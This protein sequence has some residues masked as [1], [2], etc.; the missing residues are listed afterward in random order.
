MLP[1]IVVLWRVDGFL[2]AL[3]VHSQ[4]IALFRETVKNALCILARLN[5]RGF[6]V[7]AQPN[8]TV[9]TGNGEDR[10]RGV[11]R[12]GV[13]REEVRGERCNLAGLMLAGA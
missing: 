9:T 4:S 11:K 7:S 12:E 8:G 3:P 10:G 2:T 5:R 13:K 1:D 6:A